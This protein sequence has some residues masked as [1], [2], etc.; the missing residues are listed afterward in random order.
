M[1]P[2]AETGEIDEH[3]KPGV[4][5]P[6]LAEITDAAGPAA[7]HGAAGTVD[8]TGQEAV[9][10]GNIV[11]ERKVVPKVPQPPEAGQFVVPEFENIEHKV[12]WGGCSAV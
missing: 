7:I 3:F 10:G 11:V 4:I 6:E 12:H 1:L 2:T 5:I 8:V 9:E